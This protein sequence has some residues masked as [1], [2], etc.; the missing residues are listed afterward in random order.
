MRAWIAVL[1]LLFLF[2]FGRT[3]GQITFTMVYDS[4]NFPTPTT[5]NQGGIVNYQFRLDNNSPATFQD[6]LYFFLRTPQGTFLL[7]SY[8]SITIGPFDT[9]TFV[10]PD[11]VVA[12][13]YGGGVNVVVVWP[14][15]PSFISSDSAYGTLTV[16]P[17]SVDPLSH[18]GP[19]VHVYPNPCHQALYFTQDRNALPVARVE[20]M[21]QT[22]QVILQHAGLPHHLPIS[23]L[24]PGLYLLRIHDEQRGCATFKVVK[25]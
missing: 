7:E 20:L 17:V 4:M 21:D 13:R 1:T 22:G 10:I 11:T 9:T 8:D 6:S 24:P 12:L 23:E 15:A 14:T 3:F 19:R 18:A 5:Q 16:T 2:G 25:Q